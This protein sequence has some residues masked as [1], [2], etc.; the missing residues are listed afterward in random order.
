M[1]IE[2]NIYFANAD[3]Y[4][5]LDT[6]MWMDEMKDRMGEDFPG[7]IHAFIN[8]FLQDMKFN[9]LIPGS[10]QLPDVHTHLMIPLD[11]WFLR[12]G[13]RCPNY[14]HFDG[15]N[16]SIGTFDID[17]E[18]FTNSDC[19]VIDSEDERIL[20]GRVLFP[21]DDTTFTEMELHLSPPTQED[22]EIPHSDDEF[23][24]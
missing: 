6:Q 20:T 23:S 11:V 10:E 21:D 4:N 24:D 9:T 7:H 5:I 22:W 17:D 15:D 19:S 3:A 12:W 18:S 1:A 8:A 2:R 13:I 14:S 16:A